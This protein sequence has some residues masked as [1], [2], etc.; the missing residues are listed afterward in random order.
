LP[1]GR[2]SEKWTADSVLAEGL[3]Y[4]AG[5][6]VGEEARAWADVGVVQVGLKGTRVG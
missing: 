1:A 3:L 4:A 6:L 2:C 5:E